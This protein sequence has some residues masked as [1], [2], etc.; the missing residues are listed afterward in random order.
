MASSYPSMERL[1]QALEGERQGLRNATDAASHTRLAKVEKDLAQLYSLLGMD[2]AGAPSPPQEPWDAGEQSPSDR[3]FDRMDADGDGMVTRDEFAAVLG[4]QS[5]PLA[6]DRSAAAAPPPA[7]AHE[8]RP[9]ASARRAARP[10]REDSPSP[11]PRTKSKLVTNFDAFWEEASSAT[12]SRAPAQAQQRSTSPAHRPSLSPATSRPA[13]RDVRAST[14]GRAVQVAQSPKRRA[15]LSPRRTRST[16]PEQQRT[17][18]HLAT[19]I[20]E[21]LQASHMSLIDAFDSFDEDGNRRID[22][23][24]LEVGL[25]RVMPGLDAEQMR[26][27][28]DACDSDGDGTIDVFEFSEAIG[29]MQRTAV[30]KMSLAK[31]SAEF[32]GEAPEKEAQEAPVPAPAPRRDPEWRKTIPERASVAESFAKDHGHKGS[33]VGQWICVFYDGED[34]R[35]GRVTEFDGAQDAYQ[36]AWV[37][38]GA[39]GSDSTGWIVDLQPGDY[40]VVTSSQVQQAVGVSVTG[41]A[42]RRAPQPKPEP[43]PE[44]TEE[45]HD[46]AASV[47]KSRG[48]RATELQQQAS[49]PP[50]ALPLGEALEEQRAKSSAQLHAIESAL[51]SSPYLRHRWEQLAANT[52]AAFSKLDSDGDG[53]VTLSEL[54]AAFPGADMQPAGHEPTSLA[55]A[56]RQ[57]ELS[58]PSPRLLSALPP[59]LSAA[60][61]WSM[62]PAG[63]GYS[64][65]AQQRRTRSAVEREM[66]SYRLSNVKAG[67]KAVRHTR[68]CSL[69]IHCPIHT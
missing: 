31:R 8:A 64:S 60:T 50:A 7:S 17:A 58:S 62:R 65:L 14:S 54:R 18:Q 47:Q 39:A 5:Q 66:A 21:L 10:A 11:A 20:G 2:T 26:W 68:T 48:E 3:L 45:P 49:R 13:A 43:E 37:G 25:R 36:I 55:S 59:T 22:A 53:V 24:E 19:E 16:S 6:G 32:W 67:L 40:T 42:A 69:L 33:L 57:L 51:G 35:Y 46:K 56:A 28:L 52:E 23:K 27:L 61:S 29:G 44:P 15:A 38:E 12:S 63:S 1:V 30:A 4:G 41:R 34:D 9:L